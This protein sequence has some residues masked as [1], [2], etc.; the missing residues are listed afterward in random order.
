MEVKLDDRAVKQLQ[1]IKRA[2]FWAEQETEII[3]KAIGHYYLYHLKNESRK[4]IRG[5]LVLR[6]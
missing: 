3:N 5:R 1:V 4:K 2:T 6:Q